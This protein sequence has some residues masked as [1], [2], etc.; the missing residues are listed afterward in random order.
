MEPARD[1]FTMR[2]EE[3]SL[4][5]RPTPERLPIVRLILTDSELTQSG[6]GS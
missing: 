1:D 3:V 2:K 4:Q 5:A 6:L